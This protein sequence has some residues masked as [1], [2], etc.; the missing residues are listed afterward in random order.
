[1]NDILLSQDVYMIFQLILALALG[2]MLGV[3][4]EA[5]GKPAGMRTYALVSMGSA[6]FTIVS[7]GIFHEMAGQAGVVLDPS[8]IAYAIALGIGFIG[9]GSILHRSTQVEGITPAAGIWVAG[10]IGLAVGMEFYLIAIFATAL[11]FFVFSGLRP[12]KKFVKEKAKK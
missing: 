4:R 5:A 7:L 2:G 12:V 6:L 11:S 8:R 9:G 1:M 3:E 10:A